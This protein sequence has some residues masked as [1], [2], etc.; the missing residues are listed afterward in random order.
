MRVGGQGDMKSSLFHTNV[1]R[2]KLIA[3]GQLENI[4]MAV[5]VDNLPSSMTS[6]WM[7]QLFSHEGQVI[8][9]FLSRK[10]RSG[11]RT[12]FAFVRYVHKQDALRA[13]ESMDGMVIKD[14]RIEVQEAKYKRSNGRNKV[15]TGAE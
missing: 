11:N 1:R 15:I 8:D 7:W 10:R 2:E 3:W 12:P 13:I 6:S 14:K 9:V 5:F 4:S